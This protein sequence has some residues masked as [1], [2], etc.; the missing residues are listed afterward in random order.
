MMLLINTVGEYKGNSANSSIKVV[1]LT[2]SCAK[3]DRSKS[4]ATRI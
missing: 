4:K 3:H 1:H 2:H